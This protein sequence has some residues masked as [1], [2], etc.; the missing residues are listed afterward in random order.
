MKGKILEAR[1]K[2]ILKGA[3]CYFN[4]VRSP[5]SNSRDQAGDVARRQLDLMSE[6]SAYVARILIT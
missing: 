4:A 6:I 5:H 1:G 3:C 2:Q